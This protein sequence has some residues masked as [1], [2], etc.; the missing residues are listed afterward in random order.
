MD[1]EKAIDAACKAFL[2][3]GQAYGGFLYGNCHVIRDFRKPHREQEIWSMAEADELGLGRDYDRCHREMVVE[4]NRL[5]MKAA[6]AAY[7]TE[8]GKRT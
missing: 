6:I 2:E 4:M 8:K 7:E 3:A 1:G 5:Q